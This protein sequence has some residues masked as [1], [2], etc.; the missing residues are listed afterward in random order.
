MAICGCGLRTHCCQP[1][2]ARG[3]IYADLRSELNSHLAPQA[4]F[5]QSSPVCE[6]LLQAFP[7][8]GTLG[9]VTLHPLSQACMFIYSSRGKWVFPPLL[10][11]LL[12]TATLTSFPAPGC[13]L[14]PPEPLPPGPASLFPVLG[15]IPLPRSL[16]LR[17]PHP[18]C[19]YLYC[20]YCLLLSF[21]FFPGWG[22]VCPGGYANLTQGCLWKYRVPFSSPC[23]PR[24]PK[25]SGCRH[26]AARDPSW[27]LC[28][29]WSEML[30]AGWSCGGVKVLP[31]L[32]GLACKVC[33]QR[34]SKIL[35]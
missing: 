11:S 33:L 17:A 8:P 29:T 21:S 3:I 14:L 19:Y 12:P 9:E 13:W 23:G 15:R 2:V 24:L 7:F 6:P 1:A 30:C 26:L 28:S 35:L 5:T 10:W 34:L 32:G 20:S 27:F 4:F 31:L 16:A 22:S 25:P 18:L